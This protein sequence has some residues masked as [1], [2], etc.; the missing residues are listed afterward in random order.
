MNNSQLVEAAV[1]ATT[2]TDVD[3]IVEEI[4]RRTGGV[5]LRPIGDR[6][7]NRGLLSA[8]GASF[9]I[10]II[11]QP[12][13]M[14]DA[15]IER[16]ALE[17]FGDIASVPYNSPGE[18]AEDL[19]A[20]GDY[21]E[22]G[23]RARV[24]FRESDPP[25]SRTQRITAVFRDTGVGLTPEHIPGT[26]FALGSSHKP[27]IPWFQG[28]F[29]V[30]GTTPYRNAKAVVLASRRVPSL[31]LPDELDRIALTVVL[32]R[33]LGR[34]ATACYLVDREWTERTFDAVPLGIPATDAPDFE[35]G[36][37]IA[38]ISYGVE[39][40][41]RARAGDE[42]SFDTVFDTRLMR[43]LMPVRWEDE[44]HE[45][46]DARYLRGLAHRL[47]NTDADIETGDDTLPFRV[48][49]VTH[50]LP[51]NWWIFPGP[52]E[53]GERKR[54]VAKDHAVIF[55]SNGQTHHHWSP[56]EFR[57]RTSLSKLHDRLLVEVN[58]DALPIELRTALFTSDRAGLVRGDDAVRLEGQVAAFL[59]DQHELRER[60]NDL[61][62][63][64]IRGS[65]A[66]R[67]TLRISQAISRA[68]RLRG[69]GSGGPGGTGGGGRERRPPP[70]PPPPPVLHEDPTTLTGPGTATAVF[71]NHRSITYTLDGFDDFIP[72]RS[73]VIVRCDH[74][75]ID[76]HDITVGRLRRG[77]FRITISIPDETVT[78]I[79]SLDVTVEPWLRVNGG[80]ADALTHTTKLEILAERR[81]PPAGAGGDPGTSGTT[82][83]GQVAM[84]WASHF[85]Q[86]DWTARTVGAV[87][88][89][90]AAEL[91][92]ENSD[93]AD[94]A[95]LGD[96]PIP[97][98]LLNEHY[99][100]LTQYLGARAA[101]IGEAAL[102]AN[103]ERYAMGVGLGLLYLDQSRATARQAG[104][105]VEDTFYAAAQEAVG[106]STVLLL[107]EFQ[108]L[109]DET[110]YED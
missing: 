21:Q 27:Q 23:R 54:F 109:M 44:I 83:G 14:Q 84:I 19:F 78:G 35:P 8:G 11:E 66:R 12:T 4:G 37:H 56:P 103:R 6:H 42:K 17:R 99:A 86:D 9:D 105:D 76:A 49:G 60:N 96:L 45:H 41:H 55:T 70:P 91:A 97:T 40:Y 28:A 58:T 107:P 77:R 16:A 81:P 94:L 5:H 31:L 75:E 61:I 102:D 48:N 20:G 2:L 32:W 59:N 36:T 15:I 43:P 3:T 39:G 79:F 7:N 13:N 82:E 101:D 95:R 92:A 64:A 65:D 88:M 10:K 34:N 69:F 30:G 73:T 18:A 51:I 74:P 93:Y 1:A 63:R 110:G 29:G 90:P 87:E 67:S 80:L 71:G 38:L 104:R 98:L 106:R 24:I 25:T 72:R 50:H 100:P 46:A 62:R 85:D 57:T 22:L 89:V 33:Q 26:V 53:P 47:Q 68:L 108:R 52:R